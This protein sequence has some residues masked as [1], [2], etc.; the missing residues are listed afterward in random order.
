M[1]VEETEKSITLKQ[2]YHQQA[3]LAICMSP[4]Q[5]EKSIKCR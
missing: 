3:R 2:L 5:W 4:I 1:H